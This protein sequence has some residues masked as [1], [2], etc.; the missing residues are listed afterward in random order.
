MEFKSL[1]LVESEFRI[2]QYSN[3]GFSWFVAFNP[4]PA[5]FDILCS[6]AAVRS[7]FV[8]K[9]SNDFNNSLI[10]LL[11]SPLANK[12][13]LMRVNS[14]MLPS[15]SENFTNSHMPAGENRVPTGGLIQ[16]GA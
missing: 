13:L 5:C 10:S 7:L 3:S 14:M 11:S 9:S 4:L 16:R 2:L 6:V 1:G 15:Y 12:W 8:I